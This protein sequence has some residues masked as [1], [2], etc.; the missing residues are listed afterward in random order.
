MME[1]GETKEVIVEMGYAGR[2][3]ERDFSVVAWGH[4]GQ[5]NSL[6]LTHNEGLATSSFATL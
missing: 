3:I 1:A 5:E 6:R 2:D 4:K